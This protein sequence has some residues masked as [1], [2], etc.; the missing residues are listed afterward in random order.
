MMILDAATNKI[1]ATVSN[2]PGTVLAVSPDGDEVL[3]TNGLPALNG[4]PAT[5]GTAILLFD[6]K[7]K[8]VTTETNIAN[9][10]SADFTP[11][12]SKA[13][14]VSPNTLFTVQP[15]S[16]VLN[17]ALPSA[18]LSGVTGGQQV[19]VLSAGPVGYL[20]T[21]G[22]PFFQTCTPNPI[23][24]GPGGAPLLLTSLPD[25]SA[26]I[27]AE[28]GNLDVISVSL[29]GNNTCSPTVSNALAQHA[30][31]ASVT[32]G[33]IISTAD[34]KHVYVTSSLTGQL[35]HYDIGAAAVAPVALANA[36]ATLTGGATPDNL[37]VYVGGTDGT[38]H[39]I[40]V[41]SQT[42]SAQIPVGFTPDLVVV[43]P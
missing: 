12:S 22:T 43:R 9:V 27:G 17:T 2:A 36:A 5:P 26:M 32:P 16:S 38:V 10:L 30:F 28:T 20:G 37:S 18:L 14:A 24:A 25:G 21:T 42:D 13:F 11:D 6:V 31:P 34:S 7:N 3:L 4:N 19:A 40:D 33:E 41:P 8:S 35:L 39:H 23:N 1:T 29:A 15:G